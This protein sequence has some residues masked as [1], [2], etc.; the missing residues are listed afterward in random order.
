LA[1]DKNGYVYCAG[2]ITVNQFSG[3]PI[4]IK[5]NTDLLVAKIDSAGILAWVK[6]EGNPGNTLSGYAIERHNNQLYVLGS[7]S[8][9]LSI[10]ATPLAGSNK[11]FLTTYDLQ[12]ANQWSKETDV[13]SSWAD[14]AY[15][16]LALNK[17]NELFVL[18]NS[19]STF[20]FGTSNIN[21]GSVSAILLKYTAAGSPDW[22]LNYA[23]S[24]NYGSYTTK[25]YC[26]AYNHLFLAGNFAGSMAIAGS[27]T[28]NA[29][30]TSNYDGFA[31]ILGVKNITVGLKELDLEN[32][33][34]LCPNPAADVLNL[35]GGSNL[36]Y[37][38]SITNQLGQT[39]LQGSLSSSSAAAI[40]VNGLNNGI[41]FITIS[42]PDG[43]KALASKKF[44]IIR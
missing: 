21:A 44:L 28:L 36:N 9:S 30:G 40:A 17:Q 26:D 33:F 41:Y 42:T 4:T 18:T 6:N 3:S 25:I 31:S 22:A 15:C 10:S 20:L 14:G 7:H 19:S 16:D 8:S 35:S 1:S 39:L 37:T 29:F 27:N 38:Y 2:N 13:A 43:N 24:V 5:G 32:S 34:L 11:F 12:G 23:S